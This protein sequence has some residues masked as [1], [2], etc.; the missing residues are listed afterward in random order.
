MEY[1]SINKQKP[2]DHTHVTNQT[3]KHWDFD[4]FIPKYLAKHYNTQSDM[5]QVP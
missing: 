5:L 3:W 1:T 4:Q 2:K